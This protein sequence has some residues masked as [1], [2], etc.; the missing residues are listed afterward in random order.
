MLLTK[1]LIPISLRK[2]LSKQIKGQLDGVSLEW[3]NLKDF[4]IP[5]DKTTNGCP[6]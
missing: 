2:I 1:P 3:Q 4:P 5:N 6:L